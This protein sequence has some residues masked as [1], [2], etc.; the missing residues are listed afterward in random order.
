MMLFVSGMAVGYIV[1]LLTLVLLQKN[2]KYK[3]FPG[4][5]SRD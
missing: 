3:K 2:Q 1:S 4:T 5:L